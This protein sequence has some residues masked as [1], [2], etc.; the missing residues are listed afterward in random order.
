MFVSIIKHV[1]TIFYNKNYL[2]GGQR[3]KQVIQIYSRRFGARAPNNRIWK[4]NEITI[5]TGLG[6]QVCMDL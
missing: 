2:T 1:C 3:L 6:D 5:M 4:K